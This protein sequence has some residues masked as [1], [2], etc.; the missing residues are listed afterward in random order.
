MLSPPSRKPVLSEIDKKILKVLL[1]PDR[2]ITSGSLAG[3]LGI[4]RTTV[5]RRRKILEKRFLEFEYVLKLEELGFRRVDFLISTE[6]GMSVSVGQELLKRDEVVYVGRS[7]GQHTIDLKAEVILK[8]N[9]ELLELLEVVK[10]MDGV[11]EVEWT[12]I[13]KVL[14][15]KRSIPSGIIDRM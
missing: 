7:V 14:G 5:Q 13:V 1:D 8:D 3:Q 15:R 4:P 6:S 2:R 11:K 10:G 12:E 9:S